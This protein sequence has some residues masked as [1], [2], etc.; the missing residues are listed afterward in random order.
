[1]SRLC[2]AL[3]SG[4][5]IF[6]AQHCS[7]ENLINY[8]DKTQRLITAAIAQTQDN[9]TYNGAYFKITYPMGD[10]PA[11]YGVCTDVI[12]RAYRKLGI[13]LQQLVHEDMRGN[14][15]L[16]PAK[17]NWGQTKTDTNIDHRRVPNLQTFFTRHG[18]KLIG[19]S[20]PQ[21]YQAGDLVTWMLP[22]NFPHIGIVSD[23]RS[24]D[25]LRPLIVHNIGA[26]PQLED[27]LFDYTISGHYRYA[28][29]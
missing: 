9:V 23:R 24:A 16:Y 28:L 13:D 17:K 19:S 8:A 26:G 22:G 5:L 29:F 18:K 27:M 3:F 20:N 25:G 15:S 10:V 12:I 6:I 11:Q 4:L 7:A 21:D 2:V 1:M 14:F